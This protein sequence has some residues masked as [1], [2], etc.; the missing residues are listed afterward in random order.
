[1][2]GILLKK[3][4]VS[5]NH[6]D[7]KFKVTGILKPYFTTDTLFI[8]YAEDVSMVPESILVAPFVASIMPLMWVTNTVMW[9]EEIDQTFYDSIH[10]VRDA[11]QRLYSHYPL[12]GNIISARFVDNQLDVKRDA[13]L[14]FSGG[15]DAN[16]TYIRIREQNPMLFNIQGWYKQLS[17]IDHAA[18]ADIRDCGDFAKREGRDFTYAKSNF[19]KVVREDLWTK[20]IRPKF[21]DSWWHGFQHSMAF[22]T[23]AM[24]LAYKHGI[25]NI[26]IASSVP[27]GEFCMCA[28][29]VTT[30][31]EFRYAGIGKCVHDGSE[32]VRQGKV[33]VVVGYQR[34]ID[35][36]YPM[37]V[38]S[39]NDH[40]C[41]ECEKC[42]RTVLGLVGEAANLADFGF[43]FDKPLKDYW[44]DVMYRRSGLMSFRSEKVLH[45]PYIIPRMKANYDRM[46]KEQQEFVDWFLTFDFDKAQ[47]KSRMR[48]YRQNF[49]S[50]LKRKLHI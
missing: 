45:W 26:Y 12:Q 28:S 49:W 46:T 33:Q 1:M 47:K 10:R 42:F 43:Y 11:Y 15:L 34:K 19:A 18:D 29:H 17:D 14:L 44:A 21:G 20:N 39:F 16:C 41:C 25:K 2:D 22:I 37:R 40:N 38:C 13:L 3:I 5:G 35:K 8:D 4:I 9:V 32:L 6:V 27:M 50:I 36:P 23:I 7:Y 24:P 31:S 48:Y 30:D